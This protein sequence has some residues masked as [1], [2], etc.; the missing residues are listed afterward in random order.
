MTENF[1]DFAEEKDEDIVLDITIN[2][3]V[4]NL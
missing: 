2:G 1:E 4:Y 3:K